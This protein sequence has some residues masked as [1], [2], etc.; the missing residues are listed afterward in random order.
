MPP[1]G[2]TSVLA[3]DV[4]PDGQV[5]LSSAVSVYVDPDYGSAEA[6]SAVV[7]GDAAYNSAYRMEGGQVVEGG[8]DRVGGGWASFKV[9]EKSYYRAA[10]GFERTETYGLR[11][12]GTLFRWD[13]G[14]Q[15]KTSAPGFAAVKSMALISKT[16]TYDTFLA[17]TRGGALYTI[18]IPTTA[19]MKPVVRLV[20]RSTWQNFET[21]VAAKCGRYGTL[22]FGLDKQTGKG[23]LYAVGHANGLAT[24]IQSR[25]EVATT[26]TDPVYFHMTRPDEELFG[27]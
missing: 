14:W 17:N 25:G 11:G 2:G 19:P 26:Y 10:D 9:L 5:R 4:F 8:L 24:V 16:R 13:R 12:D 3:E 21:M 27:E 7:M 23:Y 18:H 22:L 15:H 20:R 1:T 6:S